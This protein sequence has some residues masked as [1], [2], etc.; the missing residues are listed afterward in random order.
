LALKIQ[1][2]LKLGIQKNHAHSKNGLLNLNP[3]K[4]PRQG[5]SLGQQGRVR[6]HMCGHRRGERWRVPNRREKPTEQLPRSQGN[7]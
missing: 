7:I 4:P 2:G 5:L 1:S 6:T 3:G